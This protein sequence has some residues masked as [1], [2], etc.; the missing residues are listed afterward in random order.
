[1]D[2]PC[3]QLSVA[4]TNAAETG[5][6]AEWLPAGCGSSGIHRVDVVN[7]AVH[8]D[9]GYW[10]LI[11]HSMDGAAQFISNLALDGSSIFRGVH[12]L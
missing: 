10:L 3:Q 5:N 9:W 8:F 11:T 7:E 1:M 2:S 12:R 4:A 6:G